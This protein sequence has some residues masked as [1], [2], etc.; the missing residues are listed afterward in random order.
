MNISYVLLTMVMT[1]RSLTNLL[2][3]KLK[4]NESLQV[5]N[6]MKDQ[7]FLNC[8]ERY[9]DMIDHCKN[10]QLA[11][12]KLKPEKNS[13]LSGIQIHDLCDKGAVFYQKSLSDATLHKNTCNKKQSLSLTSQ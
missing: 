5:N 9:E 3:N 10:A 12:V 1:S 8:G 11:T 7:I 13:G 2:I 6:Y 4:Q